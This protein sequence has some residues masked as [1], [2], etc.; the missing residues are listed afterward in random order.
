MFKQTGMSKRLKMQP[1]L[2]IVELRESILEGKGLT[3]Q[4]LSK[5]GEQ[6]VCEKEKECNE[7]EKQ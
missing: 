1:L 4:D 7:R 3:E 5:G 2:I 6:E